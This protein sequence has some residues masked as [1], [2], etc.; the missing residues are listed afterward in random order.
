MKIIDFCVCEIKVASTESWC[1]NIRSASLLIT[2]P[3]PRIDLNLELLLIFRRF[4]L[5]FCSNSDSVMQITYQLQTQLQK[6]FRSNFFL[7]FFFFLVF[8]FWILNVYI[9]YAGTFPCHN[10]YDLI[11]TP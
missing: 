8:N 2:P 4:V 5:D 7:F 6:W 10:R 3:K 9:L 11:H 1:P